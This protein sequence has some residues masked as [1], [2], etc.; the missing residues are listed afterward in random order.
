MLAI[1]SPGSRALNAKSE[2]YCRLRASAQPR[3]PAY[4]EA[5][6][7][8]N[9]CRF[10]RRPG[11]RERIG[12]LSHQEEELIGEKRRRI[13]RNTRESTALLTMPRF[14]LTAVMRITLNSSSAKIYAV[15][16]QGAGFG[17]AASHQRSSG[18]LN[19]VLFLSAN[20]PEFR[21]PRAVSNPSGAVAAAALKT[22]RIAW[23]DRRCEKSTP[24]E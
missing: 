24:Q 5:G 4:P 19:R 18:D 23:P 7:Y 15:A 9:A 16:F 21:Q 2:K 6:D 13:D 17:E 20:T 10:E 14:S 11:V 1:A 3:I 8:S 12:Y 22:P